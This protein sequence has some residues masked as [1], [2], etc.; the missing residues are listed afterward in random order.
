[1]QRESEGLAVWTGWSEHDPEMDS[2]AWIDFSFGNLEMKNPNREMRVKMFQ[3]AMALSARVQGVEGEFYGPD[4]EE[5]ES[6]QGEQ[7][8][9]EDTSSKSKTWWKFW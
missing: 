6:P 7:P 3:I 8:Q 4:G 5:I 1:M 2:Q 9:S